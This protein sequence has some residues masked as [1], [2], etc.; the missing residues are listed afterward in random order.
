MQSVDKKLYLRGKGNTKFFNPSGSVTLQWRLSEK[1]DC[2]GNIQTLLDY[3]NPPTNITGSW[4]YDGMFRGC[5]N[6]TTAPELPA[7]TLSYCCY[8]SMFFNC[9]SLTTAPELPSTT[10]TQFCYHHMFEGCT[11]LTTAPELPATT[12][13][14]HCYQDMFKKCTNLTTTPELPATTLAKSCYWGMFAYTKLKVNT[15][16][17]NKIFTCPSSIPSGAVTEMFYETSG[18]FTGTPTAGNTYYYTV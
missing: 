1:A 10:L 16:S 13:M 3:E 18:A 11:S 2:S 14:E 7:T 4:C 17:G 6:L 9:T 5:A 8:E 15:A 12:L